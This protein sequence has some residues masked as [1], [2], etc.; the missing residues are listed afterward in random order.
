M[1][2]N[3]RIDSVEDNEIFFIKLFAKVYIVYDDL[4]EYDVGRNDAN[5]E[6]N[7]IG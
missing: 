7:V 2:Q 4:L 3:N 6:N 5:I 1:C